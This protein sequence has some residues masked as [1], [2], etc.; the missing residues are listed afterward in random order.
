MRRRHPNQRTDVSL[1]KTRERIALGR[2]GFVSAEAGEI[3]LPSAGTRTPSI[4]PEPSTEKD[5]ERG[6]RWTHDVDFERKQ[7]IVPLLRLR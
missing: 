5:C 4:P 7:L 2:T 3:Q 1:L 6:L